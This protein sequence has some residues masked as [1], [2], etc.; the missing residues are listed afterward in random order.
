MTDSLNQEAT[1]SFQWEVFSPQKAK[2]TISGRLHTHTISQIWNEVKIRQANWLKGNNTPSKELLLDA[3][4]ISYL[5]GTGVAFLIDIQHAQEAQ[6]YTF[7]L[8]GLD[9]KYQ[10]LLSRF[11][12]ID[13]LYP[14]LSTKKN[15]G[16]I[17]SVGKASS[18]F[19]KDVSQFIEFVGKVTAGFFWILRKP[20]ELRWND[21]V[22]VATQAGIYALPIITLV[23]FLIG[24]ILAFQTAV[25]LMQFGAS[26]YVAPLVSKGIFRELGPLITA[27]L[28]A[29]RSS[30][31]FAAEIGTMTVNSEVDALTTAGINPIRF[32]VMPR[33]LA[34]IIV[35]PILTIFANLIS[36]LAVILTMAL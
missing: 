24:V 32:L 5:D 23:S 17:Y 33:V 30:A 16:F 28:F 7:I 1:P 4:G 6:K 29:G 34:G 8:E 2:L 11:Q 27:I 19:F 13:D 10:A 15:E 25:G 35:V 22:H 18:I 12:P 36:V 3:S 31:A 20:K 26:T 14:K 21:L 9:P